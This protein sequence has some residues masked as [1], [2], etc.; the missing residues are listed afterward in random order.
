[1]AAVA[2]AS[3]TAVKHGSEGRRSC[4]MDARTCEFGITYVVGSF[5]HCAISSTPDWARHVERP[6]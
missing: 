4:A 2:S 6:G 5:Y 3:L 1:M